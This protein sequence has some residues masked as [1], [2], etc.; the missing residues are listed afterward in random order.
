MKR[1]GVVAI[2]LLAFAGLADATYLAQHA[3]SGV[4]LQ[5]DIQNL[6]GCNI[7]TTSS[8]SQLFGIPIAV[9]GV[10]FFAIVFVLAALELVLF[11]RLLRRALQAAAVVGL[12]A[13][14][15]FTFVQ[16][17]LI[18][19]FCIYC[20]TSALIELSIFLIATGLEPLRGNGQTPPPQPPP[21]SSLSMPP[22]V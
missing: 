16:T 12:L 18:G 19:A 20:L 6:S 15:Y 2:L 7:V 21:I 11:D 4:P 14:L 10:F 1:I 5:C 8:Y 9:Y 22:M 3:E 13:S 17:F